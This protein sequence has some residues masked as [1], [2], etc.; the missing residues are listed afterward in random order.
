MASR[1]SGTLGTASHS[2]VTYRRGVDTSTV[3][4]V[5]S[6]LDMSIVSA[7]NYKILYYINY[8]FK[9]VLIPS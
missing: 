8:V 7:I 4:I 3:F 2:T 6:I 9:I 5:R 1:L